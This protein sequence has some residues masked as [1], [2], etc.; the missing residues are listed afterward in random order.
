M[1]P[2]I[3]ITRITEEIS[4]FR[5]CITDA[6]TIADGPVIPEIIGILVPIIATIKLNIIAPHKPAPA[7]IPVATPNANACGS[8]IIAAFTPPKVSPINIFNLFFINPISI[9]QIVT[10]KFTN[11][12]VL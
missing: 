9:K 10:R 1:S 6:I 3:N 8:A 5:A 12:Y 7:P 2:A 11:F 4:L